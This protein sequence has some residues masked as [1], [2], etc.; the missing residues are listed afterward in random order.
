M[1]PSDVRP[2]A[3]DHVTQ[4]ELL[5]RQVRRLAVAYAAPEQAKRVP[6]GLTTAEI[7]AMR[8]LKLWRDGS[9]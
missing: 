6:S 3:E 5:R 8:A 4:G 2:V 1:T 7:A 9:W